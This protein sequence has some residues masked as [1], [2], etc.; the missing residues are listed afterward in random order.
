MEEIKKRKAVQSMRIGV[1]DASIAELKVKEGTQRSI[2]AYALTPVAQR[3]NLQI[4]VAHCIRW[5]T[6]DLLHSLYCCVRT[7][8][9]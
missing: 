5:S 8:E 7:S 6:C 4:A 3:T 1:I 2:A 9:P